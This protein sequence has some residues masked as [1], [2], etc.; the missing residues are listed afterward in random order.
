MSNRMWIK[1]RETDGLSL[2]EI[3]SK[4]YKTQ[5]SGQFGVAHELTRRGY[6]VTFTI[7]NAP[8]ADLLCE[9]PSGK[10]FSVQVKS[11]S[12]KTYFLYQSALVEPDASRFFVFVL[13]PDAVD[14]RPEYFVLDN[15]QFRQ[16]VTE[17]EQ[18][19]RELEEKRGK[20]YGKFS[21]GIN[22]KI[23]ARHD[24]LDAWGNIPQ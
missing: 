2:G 3:M 4:K 5:W 11:L 16:V 24:F 12:S 19:S 23:L 7:G 15:Q 20:P 22:Y 10:V 6:L 9:S 13:I 18:V 14:Q 8:A 21:P 17:Q 1:T